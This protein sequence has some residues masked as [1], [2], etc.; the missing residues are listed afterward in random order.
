VKK[1]TSQSSNGV[2]SERREEVDVPLMPAGDIIAMEKHKVIC[3][4]IDGHRVKM[5]TNYAEDMF[6]GLLHHPF[7][8][9]RHKA[10][11]NHW[12]RIGMKVTPFE[13]EETAGIVP[14]LETGGER[15]SVKSKVKA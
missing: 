10:I 12:K 3:G 15:Q 6:K 4:V 7:E 1:S 14:R 5:K 9:T 2:R 11:P 13:D 8:V